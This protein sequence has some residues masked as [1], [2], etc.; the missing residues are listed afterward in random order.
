MSFFVSLSLTAC[1]S[2]ET[3]KKPI[4]PIPY[5]EVCC[6]DFSQFSWVQ[7]NTTEEIDFQLDSDSPI[8]HF[9]DGNSYFNAF[10][11]SSRSGKVRLRLSSLMSNNSVVAP[12]LIALNNEFKIVSNT[13]LE[14]FDIKISNAFTRTQFQLNFELDATKTPYFIIYSTYSYLG[15]SIKVKHPARIRAEELGEPMP[16]VTDPTYTYERFGKL[17]LSIKTLSLKANKTPEKQVEI[18]VKPAQPETQAFYQD[19][20]TEAVNTKN[21]N[22]ALNLLDEAKKLGIKDAE[23]IF[24]NALEKTKNLL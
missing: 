4:Q 15:K 8:G 17:K 1:S 20:I 11:L 5:S 6:S 19:A 14:Q 22:K 18:T 7:L 13:N 10:K 12:K 21:M 3:V 24:I 9:S 2:T 16:M 23:N